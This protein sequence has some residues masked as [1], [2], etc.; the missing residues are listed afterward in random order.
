MSGKP[1]L[2]NVPQILV[3]TCVIRRLKGWRHLLYH[4]NPMLLLSVHT[5]ASARLQLSTWHLP[6][7]QSLTRYCNL[8]SNITSDRLLVPLG[9]YSVFKCHKPI[10]S[11]AFC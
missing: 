3:L 4:P 11:L 6:V 5:S 1:L 9:P 10:T 2:T 8:S 7:S